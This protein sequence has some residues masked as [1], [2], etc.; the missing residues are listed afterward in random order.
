MTTLAP[1]IAARWNWRTIA[2]TILA[3]LFGL[4]GLIIGVLI[5]GP[6]PWRDP[7]TLPTG[8]TSWHVAQ[9][10]VGLSLLFGALLLIGLRRPQHKAA[11]FQLFACVLLSNIVI[12]LLR[13]PA[14]G[15][16]LG[17]WVLTALAVLMLVL[18]P[19]PRELFSLKGA[20]PLSRPLLMLTLALGLLL[21]WD[22]VHNV[23]W[24]LAGVGGEQSR[25]IIW[26]EAAF[27]NLGLFIAGYLTAIKRPG[28][29]VLGVLLGLTYL[30]LGIVALTIP[31]RNGSWGAFGGAVAVLAGIAY[32]ALTVW[33]A[34]SATQAA[35]L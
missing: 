29:A 28:W 14:L 10:A 13:I 22:A 33:E 30:Y 19:W 23:Q 9:S 35:K 2:F 4:Q 8:L 25:H 5:I 7:A 24:Q 1:S 31:A 11:L 32:C 3:A 27:F 6:G 21:L 34:R 15:F 16:D 18:Y 17:G 26:L 12:A 20:G